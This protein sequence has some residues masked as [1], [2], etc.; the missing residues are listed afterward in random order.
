M[1]TTKRDV[2]VDSDTNQEYPV[3]PLFEGKR[4]RVLGVGSRKMH[5]LH[6]YSIAFAVEDDAHL[7]VVADYLEDPGF[8]HRNLRGKELAQVLAWDSRFFTALMDAPL[9]KA[10]E[11]VFHHHVKVDRMREE[12]AHG[13]ERAMAPGSRER[14]AKLVNLVKRDLG[15]GERMIFRTRGNAVLWVDFDGAHEVDDEPVARAIWSIFLGPESV[16]AS[17][18]ESIARGVAELRG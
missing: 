6:V 4:Y 11:L 1:E 15:K 17:L 10:A 14:I 3:H 9:N 12:L 7:A 5:L 16:T 2:I 13:L 18:K 8:M